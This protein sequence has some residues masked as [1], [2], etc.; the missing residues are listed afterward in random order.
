MIAHSPADQL[1]SALSKYWGY[2]SFRPLQLETMQNV[3]AGRDS[4]VVL[5]TGGGKSLCYQ[6]PAMCLDGMAVVVSPLI[7]L[8][9]DQVDAAR[10]CGIPASLLNSS[11]GITER[12]E[13]LK[14]LREGKIKLLY[15]APERLTPSGL[16]SE[17]S[18]TKLSFIA[19]DEAHCVSQWGH[20]FRPH[21]RELY[22]LRE[23]FPDV[24]VHA[25]TATATDRVRQDVIE[26]LRL[27]NPEVLIGSFDRPNLTY[28]CEPK[29][30][31]VS[32]IDDVIRRHEGESGIVYAITRK[33]VERLAESLKYMKHRVAPYHAGLT[34][35]ER[36]DNQEA[37]IEDRITT[38]VA[39]VA[40][41]MGI[42]KSDVRYVVHAAM[43]Q[44]LEHYQQESGRA[45]RDGLEAE[46]CLF[47]G[48][49]DVVTWKQTLSDLDSQQYQH[50]MESLEMIVAYSRGTICRHR[51]L[52]GHF[53]EELTNDCESACD[54]C[55]GE[56]EFVKEPLTIGQKI[57]SS[58]HRQKQRFGIEYTALVL[59]GSREGRI[60]QNGHDKL[61][62]WGILKQ[63]DKSTIMDW[64]SQLIDQQ[65][66]QKE[67]EYDV[68]K[69]TE[70]GR[71]L[72]KGEIAPR[73]LVSS[74]A[75]SSKPYRSVPGTGA[76]QAFPLF[77]EGLSLAD[78]CSRMARAESTVRGYLN[79]FIEHEKITDASAWVA[80]SLIE[81]IERAVDAVGIESPM[82]AIF[83]KLEGAV[84]YDA[85]GYVV[86][87][88]RNREG[89][90]ESSE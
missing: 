56:R 32:Q 86:R 63:E 88:R 43:P 62:T 8:M 17:L 85:I 12:R 18:Q 45:G 81:R 10:A 13:V 34:D 68:I 66:L 15:V 55:R 72:L 70:L 57:L 6:A 31:V 20:D 11:I 38:I 87:C 47:Y 19:I 89:K 42:D 7:S 14:E 1:R 9:K 25:F 2:D 90:R 59:K 77:R 28:R 41:G 46:C 61:S 29:S 27:R 84:S 48:V 79:Q 71:Q 50:A 3:L 80:P 30:D 35:K 54:I 58:I 76:L 74:R 24:G 37:F 67:G 73:L 82:T 36:K 53:G 69:I 5:P 26:Q 21:Y 75:K 52:V 78:V 4:L 64:T 49:G 83:E 40:F 51:A 44:S 22:R 33:E 65:F 39:T 60:V 23:G 16:L